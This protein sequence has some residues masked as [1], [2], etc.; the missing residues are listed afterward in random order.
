MNGF[1]GW[2]GQRGLA[3]AMAVRAW[4]ARVIPE[5]QV[6]VSPS[7]PKGEEWFRALARELEE[8]QIGLMCLSPPIVAGAWQPIEAGAIWTTSAAPGPTCAAAGRAGTGARRRGCS[9][10]SAAW[11]SSSK[12]I[13][14]SSPAGEFTDVC[15]N[16]VPIK[17]GAEM[18]ASHFR[19][20]CRACEGRRVQMCTGV[21][22]ASRRV[23]CRP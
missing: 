2:S 10:A 19:S 17:Q 5:V 14:G 13:I 16:A 21:Q 12:P 11:L 3:I 4:L 23:S 6:F 18:R 8:A 20:P 7:L 22:D 9:A 15:L 1:I